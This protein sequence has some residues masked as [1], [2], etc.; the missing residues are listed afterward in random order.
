MIFF[1]EMTSEEKIS[2]VISSFI[3]ARDSDIENFI[4]TKA[5]VYDKKVLSPLASTFLS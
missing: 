5:L 3:C 4:R 1:I 2:E